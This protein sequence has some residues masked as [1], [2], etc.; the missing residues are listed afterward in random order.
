MGATKTT[1]DPRTGAEPP[2]LLMRRRRDTPQFGA[3]KRCLAIGG[4]P[5]PNRWRHV[6]SRRVGWLACL[7]SLAALGVW[8]APAQALTFS[9]Q[10]L[11]FSGLIGP[12]G[13]A[14]DG[15]GD[16]FVLSTNQVVELRVDGSQ[17]TLPFT[18][19][20]TFPYG[21]AVDGSGDVFV[22]DEANNRVVELPA[23]GGQVTLPFSGLSNPLG[24]AVDGSGDVFVIDAG[25]HRVVELPAGGSQVTLPF[26]GLTSPFGVAVDGSGD[27]FVTDTGNHGV[28][29]LH[30]GGSQVTRP[31]SGLS[32]P[33]GVAVDGSGDVYVAD[34]INNRVVELPAGGSAQVVLPFTGLNGPEGVAVDGSGN[35]FVTDYSNNR[36]VELTPSIA[37]GSLAFAPSSGPA[38]SSI[39]VSSVTPCPVGGLLG[40]TAARLALYSSTGSVTATA[41]GGPRHLRRLDRHTHG[42]VERRQRHV[43]RR[44]AVRGRERLGD[45]ELRLCGVHRGCRQRRRP[46]SGGSYRPAGTD[47]RDRSTRPRRPR[48]QPGHE[49]DARTSRHQRHQRCGRH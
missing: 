32:N 11:G 45:P 39:G 1:T 6:R 36:V 47:R 43:F 44:C 34:T 25:N 9:Q 30:A 21:V 13:V 18:G 38:G 4:R 23:G 35:V 17:A 16:V 42:T 5:G 37:S 27:V 15:L 14:V 12:R 10:T 33:D 8:A 20:S 31:F 19:L 28:V 41:T 22:T 48:R 49:R 24:V 3:R 46:G 7:C 26:T 40:S 29:E 2:R